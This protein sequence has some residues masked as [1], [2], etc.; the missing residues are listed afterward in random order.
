MILTLDQI[1]IPATARSKY[2]GN[3]LKEL[4]FQQSFIQKLSAAYGIIPIHLDNNNNTCFA[5]KPELLAPYNNFVDRHKFINM[6]VS[7]VPASHFRLNEVRVCIFE[8]DF[9]GK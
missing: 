6:I 2:S 4:A 8:N 1:F 9:S 7:Q 5:S 3:D